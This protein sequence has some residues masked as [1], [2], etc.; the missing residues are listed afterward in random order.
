VVAL[1][2]GAD[3]RIKWQRRTR[4]EVKYGGDVDQVVPLGEGLEQ[5]RVRIFDGPTLVRTATV[6]TPEYLYT[7]LTA[8]GFASGDPVTVDVAQISATVGPGYATTTTG[9]AP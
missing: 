3:L 5:Y 6:T 9:I 4:L 7:Q 8:D 2:D 1:A